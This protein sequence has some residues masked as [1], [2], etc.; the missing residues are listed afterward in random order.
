[1][2]LEQLGGNVR[3][4]APVNQFNRLVYN[5]T[6][7]RF[8][9]GLAW[10]HVHANSRG[11]VIDW[12]GYLCMA[13]EGAVAIDAHTGGKTRS[14]PGQIHD[15]QS[16]RDGGIGVDD[17]EDA[18]RNLWG[19]D[20]IVPADY[21][22]ADLIS[23]VRA[24][25][26]V[27][28]GVDYRSVP[29]VWKGQLPGDFDHAVGID[30]I[31]SNGD[32]LVYDSLKTMPVWMPQ[33]AMRDAAEDLAGRVRG[34]RGALFC[35]LTA[36]RLQ[37]GGTAPHYKAT[38]TIPTALWN[39]ATKRW[40]YNGANNVKP[41]VRLEV[42]GAVYKMDG[43]PCYPITSGS[44]SSKYAGYYVPTKNVKLSGQV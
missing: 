4:P 36:A 10:N 12:D 27:V 31:R 37:I 11:N 44:W 18:W 21:S 13:T 26:H 29:D 2:V 41:G 15:A 40:V 35:G 20:L 38:V 9:K 34:N 30:D 33:S 19:A 23:A 5:E 8:E 28:L 24:R 43:T 39:N 1:M 17:V 3:H 16:D 25:R 32:I 6:T 7:K 14:S 22:W 42:R